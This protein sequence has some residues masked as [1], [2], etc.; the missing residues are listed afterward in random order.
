MPTNAVRTHVPIYAEREDISED[1]ALVK[2]E[3]FW[4]KAKKITEDKGLSENEG[5]KFWSYVMTIWKRMVGFKSESSVMHP[6]RISLSADYSHLESKL[7]EGENFT[8]LQDDYD[9]GLQA[10]VTVN[11]SKLGK[12]EAHLETWRWPPG[13]FQPFDL[14][15]RSDD[16]PRL[17]LYDMIK[18]G[19][20][21]QSRSPI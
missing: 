7:G 19:A 21:L 12:V 16:F 6:I 11:R 3:E 10:V 9:D 17:D 2:L 8:Y 18:A 13:A 14:K 20:K 5:S 15:Q 1:A 4:S